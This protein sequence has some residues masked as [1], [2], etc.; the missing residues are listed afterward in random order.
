M[1]LRDRVDAYIALRRGLGFKLRWTDQ[2][3][4]QFAD[5]CEAV[6]SEVVTIDLALAWARLPH[7]CQPSWWARRLNAVRPFARY[8]HALDTRHEVPP[9]DLLS[10]GS[11]RAEPFIYSDAEIA[12]LM[13]ATDRLRHPLKTA[14]YRTYI[15]LLA[16]TG[17]RAGEAIGLDRHDVQW[18][19][20]LLVVRKGKFGKSR[21]VVLHQTTLH[22]LRQYDCQRQ[23]SIPRPESSAF[24]V[25]STGR[26]L[27]Y[28]NVQHTF[29]A[30]TERVGLQARSDRCRPRLHDLRHTFAVNAL[31]GW[32]R[33]GLDVDVQ[34]H[35]LTTYLGHVAPASTYWYLSATPELMEILAQRLERQ[36]G[37]LP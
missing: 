29:H 27:V 32:Y 21:E 16:T 28:A 8:M 23:R 24:F 12:E 11:Q 36:V 30:L 25:S 14:T 18:P 20:S 35:L 15:G 7:S 4:A 6:G 22:A 34:M 17:M 31:V 5:Y 9:R 26:R 10:A 2:L 13:A 19:D 3:L 33:D 1:T 37:E